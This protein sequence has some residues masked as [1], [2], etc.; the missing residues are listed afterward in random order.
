VLVRR[1]LHRLRFARDHRWVPS[2]SSD[3][4]DGDL[5]EHDD[6]RVKRH[7]R[8]CSACRELLDGLRAVIDALGSLQHGPVE[9]TA[10]AV[11]TSVQGQ[12]GAV[13]PDSA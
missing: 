10:Q 11:L 6:R 5:G 9:P 13:P 8:E 2:R 7:L 1:L 3:Y 12:L 4:L